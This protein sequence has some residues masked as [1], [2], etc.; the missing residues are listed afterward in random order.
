MKVIASAAAKGG[1]GK[2]SITVNLAVLA[3]RHGHRTLLWDLDPQGAATH[4]LRARSRIKG[5]AVR[6]LGGKRD[7]SALV[8]DTMIDGLRVLPADPSLRTAESVLAERRWPERAIRKLLR[9]LAGDHDL[10]VLDCPPG[11]GLL[12]EAA[13]AATDLVLTPIVPSPLAARGFAQTL[14]FFEANDV[15]ADVLAVLSMVDRRKVLHRQVLADLHASLDTVHGSDG[16]EGSGSAGRLARAVIPL[17]D[18]VERM[19]VEQ[20][21]SVL[22]SPRCLASAAL[23]E[24]WS[25]VAALL[26]LG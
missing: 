16:S 3:A 12:A 21:P 23:V 6:V 20:M 10:V 15:D 5:G 18:A 17:S 9:P 2:T 4:C 14:E 13:F 1:V 7:L 26:D 24:L 25:E 19:G 22:A 11:L 8:V